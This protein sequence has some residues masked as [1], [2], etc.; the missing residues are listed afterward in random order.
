MKKARV[1]FE[2]G[3][4]VIDIVSKKKKKNVPHNIG[5]IL[6]LVRE[7]RTENVLA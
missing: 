3:R 1:Y 5:N 6:P 2:K 4:F 7:T